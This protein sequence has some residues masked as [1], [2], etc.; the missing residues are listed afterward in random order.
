MGAAIE[1][2]ER[3]LAAFWIDATRALGLT[4]SAREM[5]VWVDEGRI[6]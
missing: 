3:D 4:P 2:R 6:R 1:A 5:S